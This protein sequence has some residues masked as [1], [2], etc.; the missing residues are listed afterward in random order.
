MLGIYQ[1]INTSNGCI[2]TD[3]R[4]KQSYGGFI[5][6][7]VTSIAPGTLF[8]AEKVRLDLES[9]EEFEYLEPFQEV[10]HPCTVVS[11]NGDIICTFTISNFDQMV[12][13]PG[14]YVHLMRPML[15]RNVAM[16][17]RKGLMWNSLQTTDPLEDA[18]F[19][20]NWALKF[21]ANNPRHLCG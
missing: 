15:S 4:L 2:G 18:V 17:K 9:D 7:E 19:Q 1:P 12:R 20:M 5:S 16:L 8:Q 21:N 10:A 3:T 11:Q 13:T 14:V 6:A